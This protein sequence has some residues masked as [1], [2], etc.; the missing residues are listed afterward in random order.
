MELA[1]LGQAVAWTP[2][3]AETWWQ[4]L[5]PEKVAAGTQIR[6]AETVG[7]ADAKTD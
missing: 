4:T 6:F 3:R 2:E 1:R 7:L 5:M